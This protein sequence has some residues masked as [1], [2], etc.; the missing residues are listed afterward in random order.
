M[1]G[2]AFLEAYNAQVK[3]LEAAGDEGSRSVPPRPAGPKG[4]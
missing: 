4:G 1:F 3:S 2:E